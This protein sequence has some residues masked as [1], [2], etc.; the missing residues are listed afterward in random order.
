MI[1]T[2]NS[3][4]FDSLITS[5]ELPVLVVFYSPL[6]G[7]SHLIDETL[8]Q[9]QQEMQHQIKLLK[10]NSTIYPELASQYEVHPLPT[11]LLFKGGRLLGRI[12]EEHTENLIP[13]QRLIER[14][15]SLL[16]S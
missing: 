16:N 4:N 13:A 3:Q 11:L 8:S 10:I 7:P 14:L 12:E 1:A 2:Q 5:S 6:C 9:I 15:R